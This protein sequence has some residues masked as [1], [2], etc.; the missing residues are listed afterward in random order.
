MMS[1]GR[2]RVLMLDIGTGALTQLS[3]DLATAREPAWSAAD[4]LVVAGR[5]L[6][7]SA[8]VCG[9]ACLWELYSV[10]PTGVAAPTQLTSVNFSVREPDWS[11]DSSQLVASAR[12]GGQPAGIQTFA[13]DGTVEDFYSSG[14]SSSYYTDPVWSPSQPANDSLFALTYVSSG[15]PIVV[16][17]DAHQG[18]LAANPTPAWSPSWQP[19]PA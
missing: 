12:S 17:F 11:P 7:G 14:S 2:Y 9:T 10:D 1:T 15:T 16:V 13:A 4:A 3:T 5:P 19:V 8:G 18:L 6:I